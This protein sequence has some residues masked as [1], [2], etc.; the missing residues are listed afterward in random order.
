MFFSKATPIEVKDAIKDLLGATE[1][2]NKKK[3]KERERE[4][5]DHP[6][7]EEIKKLV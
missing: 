1:I 2:K 3:K 4:V 7:W 5:F 6:L